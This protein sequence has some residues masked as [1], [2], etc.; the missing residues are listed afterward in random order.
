MHATEIDAATAAPALPA[1]TIDG[2]ALSKAVAIVATLAPRADG[3]RRGPDILNAILVEV[4][5]TALRLT[6][7]DLQTQ[8]SID[9]ACDEVTQPGRCA[10]PARQLATMCAGFKAG[11]LATFTAE[12]AGA[13]LTGG[14]ARFSAS[15]LPADDFPLLRTLDGRQPEAVWGV[16]G[17]D[18]DA[19]ADHGA[20]GREMPAA[21]LKLLGKAVAR[22]KPSKKS[23]MAAPA[24][25]LA[26][27]AETEAL[28]GPEVYTDA[29]P[30]RLRVD[31]G[32]MTVITALPEPAFDYRS[33]RNPWSYGWDGERTAK[34]AEYARHLREAYGLPDV[35][36]HAGRLEYRNGVAVG[37]TFGEGYWDESGFRP[38][39]DGWTPPAGTE[40]EC[41]DSASPECEVDGVRYSRLGEGPWHYYHRGAQCLVYPEGAYSVFFPIAERPVI[42]EVLL[43]VDG[44]DIAVATN[45][46]G[47]INLSA[48]EI[49]ELAGPVSEMTRVEIAPMPMF[50]GERVPAG[51]IVPTP[52]RLSDRDSARMSAAEMRAYCEACRP[53][54]PAAERVAQEDAAAASIAAFAADALALPE[55][56]N[57]IAVDFAAAAAARD[58]AE[59]ETCAENQVDQPAPAPVPAGPDNAALLAMVE[60]LASRV[61][62]LETGRA[63]PAEPTSVRQLPRALRLRIV[64]AYLAG[65]ASRREEAR[66]RAEMGA[67][68][69]DLETKMEAAE[70]ALAGERA[71]RAEA[72][73]ESARRNAAMVAAETRA[74]EAEASEEAM[75][76][77][78]AELRE[79]ETEN[80]ALW[81]TIAGLEKRRQRVRPAPAAAREGENISAPIALT[82][83]A[84]AA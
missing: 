31:L 57:V 4:D 36:G 53:C 46:S 65:R 27:F 10:V 55:P 17:D 47:K 34:A 73:A 29:Q 39:P 35:D 9:L 18:P 84:A 32:D 60:R 58:A 71:A 52:P 37:M 68:R 26:R 21:A 64:G 15:V 40:I 25:S 20:E 51:L 67:F 56:S 62:A 41:E 6:A 50:Q 24:A 48:E 75:R 5:G 49:A 74:A 72:E 81:E 3:Y 7:T 43:T 33:K 30:P 76:A 77:E 45:G 69:A 61:A 11:T 82:E 63:P 8:V 12:G 19:L 70:T 44:R 2:K 66:L 1:F 83:P 23:G 54:L 28:H 42:S 38:M 78:L 13:V 14:R 16:P 22:V 80:D 59:A 79:V